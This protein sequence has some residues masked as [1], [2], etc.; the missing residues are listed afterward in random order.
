MPTD[1]RRCGN[2]AGSA[3]LSSLRRSRR[4]ILPTLGTV[5]FLVAGCSTKEAADQAPT[6]AVQVASAQDAPIQR[7][8]TA[9]AI[10][11]PRDQAAIVPR[12]NAPVKKFYVDRG[13]AVH[14]GQLLAE[15][16]NQDLVGAAAENQGGIQQAEA[17]YQ[18]ATQ[19]AEQDLQLAKAAVGRSA[20]AV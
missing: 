6:V 1:P 19:R 3:F 14:K 13:S 11:Y 5:L 15:L 10:L 18:T 7:K 4:L 2:K 8:V 12:I 9:Q 20:E 16:E 17:N